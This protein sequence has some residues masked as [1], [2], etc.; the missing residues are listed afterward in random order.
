VVSAASGQY[1]EATIYL[2]DSFSGF[3]SVR[4]VVYHSPNST[5]YVGGEGGPLL[6]V[7]ARTNAK[8]ARIPVSPGLHN[9]LCS[10]TRGNKVYSASTNT[11]TLDVID[12]ATNCSTKVI[13]VERSVTDLVYN[14]L[15]DKLYCGNGNDSLVR[16][17]DCAGDSV[18]AR[19][20]VGFGPRTL[21]YNPQLNR[22]Y[23]A[24][25][26]R[27][28][29]SVIDCAADTV[30]STIWV[31]GV[32]PFD[33]CYDSTTNCVY[34]ANAVSNTVSA[35]DCGGDTVLRLVPAGR[36]PRAVVAGP[37]G[38]VYCANYYDSSVTVISASGTRTLRVCRFPVSLSYD[39]VNHKVYCGTN[40]QNR[41]TVIDAVEDSVLTNVEIGSRSPTLC[42]NPD[43]NSTYAAG[44]DKATLTAIGGE[45]DTIEAVIAFG[46][47]YPGPMCYNTVNNHLYCLDDVSGLLFVI[48]GESNQVLKTI[49]TASYP[50]TLLWSP[51]SNKVYVSSPYNGVVSILN[52]SS[53]SIVATVAA[54]PG[55]DD[56]DC[57]DDGKVYVAFDSGVAAIDGSGD[58][59]RA[60]VQF[61][62]GTYGSPSTLCYDRTSKKMY[63][64]TAYGADSAV[65]RAID[66]RA[67][68]VEAAIAF[69]TGLFT[70]QL[71]LCC[72]E[73]YD[74]LYVTGQSSDSIVVIDCARDTILKNI[75]VAT[76]IVLSYSDLAT[77]KV[78]CYDGF[79]YCL[80]V[81][82]AAADSL[83]RSLSVGDVSA[84][85]DNGKHGPANRLYCAADGGKVLVVAG[86]KMDSV[87]RR[88]SVGSWPSALAWNPTY[89]RM[90]VSNRGSSSISVIRDTLSPGV[91]ETMNDERGTMNSRATVIRGVLNLQPAICNLQSEI[92]L[93]SSDGRKVM[94]LRP[95]ANDVRHIPPGIYF[96]R[97]SPPAVTGHPSSVTKIVLTR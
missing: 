7:D 77:G 29:V 15:D 31:R 32:A 87:I 9:L 38:K 71:G 92:V 51:A 40:S 11:A 46:S 79:N 16:V 50:D 33:I 84:I 73:G 80:R 34:T 25:Y 75:L 90:Y 62:T 58:T 43:G 1:V 96:V 70:Y 2:P 45:S 47:S 60:T 4:S 13:E 49:Q 42:F 78:Y 89:S 3:P 54:G 5:V 53:D 72:V 82:A 66:T 44:S 26:D 63:V 19:I 41:V 74:K 36:S 6:A 28:D 27:D 61:P 91:L 52:C 55:L 69:W 10:A 48:D 18:V 21:C 37:S 20:A 94:D 59:V 76:G 64:G 39:S 97:S 81:I 67:D 93:L 57:S 95:G 86:Y 88:I 24:H 68:T 65:V 22:V 85:L 8:L 83:T 23:C 35:I 30:V 56:M 12:G 14:E 17:I